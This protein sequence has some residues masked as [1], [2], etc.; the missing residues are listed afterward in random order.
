MI[1]KLLPQTLENRAALRTAIATVVT[2]LIAFALHLSKPYWAGVTVVML[3]NIYTGNIID[4]AVM[5]ITGTVIGAGVGYFIAGY[6]TNSFALYLLVSF[7]LIAIAVYYYNFSNYAY[8]CLLAA[9]S[10]FIVISEVAIDPNEAFLVAIWRPV[11]IGLGVVVSAA[12]AFCLFPNTVKDSMEKQIN[13]IFADVDALLA[14]VSQLMLHKDDSLIESIGKD[15]LALKK[16]LRKATEMIGFMRREVGFSHQKIDQF[17]LVLD[18]FFSLCRMINF[19]LVSASTH[20]S[21]DN[22]LFIPI[23]AAFHD[24]LC[25][26][27]A[28]LLGNTTINPVLQHHSSMEMMNQQEREFLNQSL[29]ITHFIRQVSRLLTN[30]ATV[31][32]S[33]STPKQTDGSLYTHQDQ[34]RNDM[35]VI[36]HSIKAGLSVILSLIFWLFSNWP[37]GLNGIIS[38]LFISI[39]KNLFEMKNISLHRTL[40][41]ILGGGLA[42]LALMVTPLNLYDLIM[43]IFFAVWGFSYFSFKKVPYAYI[44]LQANF[45][46][47][48]SLAQEGGAPTSLAPPLERLSGIFIGIAASFIVA[49]GLWRTDLW[50]TMQREMEKL[51]QNLAHNCFHLLNSSPGKKTLYELSNLFWLTRGSLETLEKERLSPTRQTQLAVVLS[52]YELLVVIQATARHIQETIDQVAACNFAQQFH[53]DLANLADQVAESYKHRSIDNKTQTLQRLN[54]ALQQFHQHSAMDVETLDQLENCNAYLL[55]L[56][57]LMNLIDVLVEKHRPVS[58]ASIEIVVN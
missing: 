3:S 52:D 54:D 24:D 47:I 40:G 43:L 10:A 1:K 37:G 57:Q 25:L 12:A 30:M 19:Y 29:S 27:K 23:F 28:S 41:C 53:I 20:S 5:R 35:D 55:T 45:A 32:G 11:E 33:S 8:A 16:K 50:K 7:L 13:T 17:R 18:S 42:L 22:T 34:L 39:R 2:L 26:L 4:K 36:K 14:K 44:G 46:L 9:V 31:S 21:N 6:I 56:I 38:S 49:N 15:H 48:I 51:K 58:E